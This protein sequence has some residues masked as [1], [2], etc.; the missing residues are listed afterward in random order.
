MLSHTLILMTHLSNLSRLQWHCLAPILVTTFVSVAEAV[1]VDVSRRA[2]VMGTV[3]ELR[4]SARDRQTALAASQVAIDAV[5]AVEDRLSTW[6]KES[7]LSRLNRAVVGAP[8]MISPE[9][10]ADLL[11]A[12]HWWWETGGLFDLSIMKPALSGRMRLGGKSIS[13]LSS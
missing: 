5:E 10:E 3:L 4:I 13:G 6:R 12:R 9:L 11:S 8:V 7:E 2:V 1:D